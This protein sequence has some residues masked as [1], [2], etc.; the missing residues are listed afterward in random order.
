MITREMIQLVENRADDQ[1]LLGY[2]WIAGVLDNEP[3]LQDK[4]DQYFEDI[5]EFRRSNRDFC[6]GP[7]HMK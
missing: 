1:P 4:P 7:G 5:K 3:A 2:D 6:V